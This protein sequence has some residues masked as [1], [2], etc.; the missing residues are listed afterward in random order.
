[1]API[2]LLM[3]FFLAALMAPAAKVAGQAASA[4][5]LQQQLATHQQRD[6]VRIKLL[7]Q[8]AFANYYSNPLKSLQCAFEA[9]NLADSVGYPAGEAEAYRQ[10]GL[11]YWAQ[12]DMAT[13][14][15]YF[16]TG[17][18]I[19]EHN[20]LRQVEADITANIGTA[21]NGLGDHQVALQYLNKSRAMQRALRNQWREA[22]VTNN[23]G[24]A[25]L[26]LRQ[27]DSAIAAYSFALNESRQENYVLG[28]NTNLRNIGN[29]W[30]Q[31]GNY[32]SAMHN[33]R[34]C[35]VLSTQSN[36]NRGR[37]LSHQSI[38]SVLYK[39]GKWAEAEKHALEALKAAQAGG[40]KAYIRDQYELLA[41][42]SEARGLQ[43]QAFD[44]FKKYVGYKDSVQNLSVLSEAN[45]ARFRF[46]TDKRLTEIQLLKKESQI[47]A[48]QVA[49]KN[50][51]LMLAGLLIIAA[52]VFL[53]ITIR[54]NQRLKLQHRELEQKNSQIDA[55]RQEL[56]RQRKQ[57]LEINNNLEEMV[58]HRTRLLEQQNHRLADYA[59]IN[60]HKLRAPVATILGLIHL[61]QHTETS[62][63]EMEELI[64]HLRKS[65]EHLDEVV[66][67]I[68]ATLEEGM[69]LY[70]S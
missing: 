11:A 23:L 3:M 49:L 8:L 34:T 53:A 39:T 31:R 26:A 40:L 67:S 70:Q 42:I 43:T 30:E 28:I 9:R 62:V 50:N 58:A 47:Q 66:R 29:V 48:A 37:I 69:D 55:Q 57:I 56:D 17:L 52:L 18:R 24:D 59:H 1:M 12:A 16:L 61:L 7:N 36:D 60:A 14:I 65:A 35:L 45:A 44:Y 20:R 2:R 5:E 13:A 64:A 38:A 54:N 25:Y 6:T 68:N 46:E 10:I 4:Q 15:N 19:A 32:D 63:A 33:Y 51:Q 22:A 21:Y 41:R 27:Y